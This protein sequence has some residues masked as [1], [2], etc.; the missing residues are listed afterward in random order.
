M[1][2]GGGGNDPNHHAQNPTSRLGKFL[3]ID[4]SVG[5]SHPAGYRVPPGNPFASSPVP[6]VWSFGLRNP[7][8]FSFDEPALGGTGGMFVADV[9]QN[10]WEEVD[11]EPAGCGGRNYGWRNREG[12]HAN[13]ESAPPAF[14][15]LTD[16]I[17]EYDHSVGSS[18]TG[19]FVYRG[20][21]LQPIMRG[22]YLFADF[23]SGRLWSVA[24]SYDS[25]GEATASGLLDHTAE[26]GG[27]ATLGNVSAFGVDAAGELYVVS[28]SRGA[29]FALVPPPD[30]PTNVRIVR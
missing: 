27:P 2:D 24:V 8:K 23:V 10:S 14:L 22:R 25:A 11:F 28:Y 18:I 4:V 19:G 17:H 13:V 6:E 12:R 21:A 3:R 7:W 29:V 16:P 30:P 20:R 5:D 1:G 26:L 9:G 15:P